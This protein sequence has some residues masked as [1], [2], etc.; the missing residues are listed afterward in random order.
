MGERAGRDGTG[1]DGR[2]SSNTGV[3]L[4]Q[5]ATNEASEAAR[6]SDEQISD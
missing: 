3:T 4:R 1:R 6:G 5:V 2:A